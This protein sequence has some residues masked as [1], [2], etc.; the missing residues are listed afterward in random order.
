MASAHKMMLNTST[1]SR[2]RLMHLISVC[3]TVA[4]RLI[5]LII[6]INNP[7]HTTTHI[8]TRNNYLSN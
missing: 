3:P 1:Y 5:T 7:Q 2:Q 6:M 4:A 8:H